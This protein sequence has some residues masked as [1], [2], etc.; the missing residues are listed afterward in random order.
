[1][2]RGCV[3]VRK[4]GDIGKIAG[5]RRAIVNKAILLVVRSGRIQEFTVGRDLEC[6]PP[7]LLAC[8]PSAGRRRVPVRHRPALAARPRRGR[9]PPAP[10]SHFTTRVSVLLSALIAY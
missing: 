10:N 4:I 1:M 7:R 5:S 8:R 9:P 2:P 3:S 6:Q